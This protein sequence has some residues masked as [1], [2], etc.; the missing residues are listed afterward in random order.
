[1]IKILKQFSLVFLFFFTRLSAEPNQGLDRY[2]LYVTDVDPDTQSFVLSNNMVFHVAKNNWKTG[3]LPEI[4][5]EMRFL[6]LVRKAQRSSIEEV[7]EFLTVCF[8][9]PQNKK[10][11]VWISKESKEHSLF[12]V[13]SELICIEPAGWFSSAIYRAIIELSDGSKW[14]AETDE[15]ISLIKGDRVILTK[16]EEDRWAIINIDQ[17]DIVKDE[18]RKSFLYCPEV[19]VFPYEIPEKIFEK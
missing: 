19:V 8:F 15:K 13:D 14:I 17:V 1:M 11:H 4:G 5:M 12:Y 2:L 18:M 10:T 6:P 3:H 9:H 16:I 7:G